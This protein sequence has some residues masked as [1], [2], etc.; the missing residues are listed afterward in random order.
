MYVG[1]QTSASLPFAFHYCIL[2]GTQP[3][4]LHGVLISQ[5]SWQVVGLG[6]QLWWLL[7]KTSSP[8][9]LTVILSA[10]PM[11]LFASEASEMLQ[12]LLLLP[13]L[14]LPAKNIWDLCC[15]WCVSLNIASCCFLLSQ[16]SE[17]FM[18]DEERLALEARRELDRQE[19]M[20]QKRVAL[21]TNKILKEQQEKE[22][23]WVEHQTRAPLVLWWKRDSCHT[24]RCIVS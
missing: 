3:S 21:E 22:R 18:T 12:N 6:T 5:A 20:H 10:C 14:D 15:T 11:H 16:G 7:T 13:S 1:T 2:P 19:L 17:L 8:V 23:Q 24:D 9:L 4:C